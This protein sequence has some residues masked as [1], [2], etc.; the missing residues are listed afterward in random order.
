MIVHV[1]GVEIEADT[2]GE[3]GRPPVLL[4]SGSGSSKD[5]WAP[6]FCRRLAEKAGFVI[7][8]DMRDTGQSIGYPVGR[9]GYTLDDLAE[10][11]LALLDHYGARRGHLVGISLG[12]GIAQL[13][14]V[15]HAD[16][17]ASLTL[18]A[19]SSGAPDL[20]PPMAAFRA[21]FAGEQPADLVERTVA[22]TRAMAARSV[23]FDEAGTRE[24]VAKEYARTKSV[25]AALRN[26]HETEG[27]EPW[28]DRLS[29]ISAP[30]LVIHGDEDPL[31]PIEHGKSLAAMIPGAE[32]LTLPRVGHELPPRAWDAVIH[33]IAD[34]ATTD[35]DRRADRLAARAV[36]AGEPT[37]W[38]DHLYREGARGDIEMPWNRQHPHPLLVEHLEGGSGAGKRGLVVGCGLGVDAG[39]LASRG[40]DTTGFDVS[41]TAIEVARQRHPGV[42]FEVADL[43]DL[44]EKWLRAFDFIVEIFTVQALPESVRARASAAVASLLAPGGTLFVVAM[45]REEGTIPDGPP[46]PLTRSQFDGFAVDGVKAV[47]IGERDGRW[48]GEF[49]R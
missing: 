1:N 2:F 18:I 31:F 14:G 11:A 32:L 10:D 17:V 38:F 36:A 48:L 46:W 20:P 35:W 16:R 12:G 21:H 33:A 30:T 42:D 13:I 44:P 27:V 24:R 7:R 19:T 4:L 43:F 29:E 28:A 41:A 23:P 3:P 45:A 22:A 47:S 6:E 40:F 37:V 26:V 34:Q 9:P 25:E 8:Y 39:Y 15:R 49:T 5:F